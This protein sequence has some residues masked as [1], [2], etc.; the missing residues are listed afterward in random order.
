MGDEV[1]GKKIIRGEGVRELRD[2]GVWLIIFVDVEVTE[3]NQE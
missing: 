1:R 2:Q 3:R